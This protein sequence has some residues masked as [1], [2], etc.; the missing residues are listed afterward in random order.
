MEFEIS[1][2]DLKF[3]AYHGY[4]EEERRLGNEFIVNLSVFVP[5]AKEME[6]DELEYTVS[7]AD[8]FEIVRIEM[9]KPCKLLETITL[10]ISKVIKHKFPM[11][12]RGVIR[13]EKVRPPIPLMLGSATVSLT[14]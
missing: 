9:M 5:L 13:I 2:N 6:H 12:S 10:N 4:F 3:Y 7:Y 14:F 11:V 1:L 8:L